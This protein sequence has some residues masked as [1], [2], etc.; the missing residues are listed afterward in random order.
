MWSY[1]LQTPDTRVSEIPCWTAG[2]ILPVRKMPQSLV[3]NKPTNPL[4][5]IALE[6]ALIQIAIQ[7][8]MP[9]QTVAV[10]QGYPNAALL[11]K[12]IPA[13]APRTMWVEAG[14]PG[15]LY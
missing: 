4:C 6:V 14:A 1:L 5:C 15:L 12:S 10:S 9:S 2:Q 7:D 8:T 11:S 13:H 3:K